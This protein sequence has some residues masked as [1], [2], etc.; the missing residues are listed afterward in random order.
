M[1]NEVIKHVTQTI[2]ERSKASRN[3][4][5]TKI[6][7]LES[8]HMNLDAIEPSNA[9]HV[10]AA[11][12][13]D[14]RVIM[15]SKSTFKLGIISSYNEM[16]SAHAPYVH[17]PELI[18]KIAARLGHSASFIGGVPAICDGVVQGYKGMELSLI[19][20]NIIAMATAIP[21]TCSTADRAILLGTCDKIVPGMLIGAL[22]R[23]YL[24]SYFIPS[25]TMTT[26]ISNSEKSSARQKFHLGDID[27]SQLLETECRCYHGEGTCTFYG[28]ANTNQVMLEALGIQ[29]IDSGL[30]SVCS[31]K[32]AVMEEVIQ[33]ILSAEAPALYEL[34][35]VKSILNA[36]VVWLATGGSTNHTLHLVAI[37][38]SAGIMLRWEDMDALS[39]VVPLLA[40][41]YP[42]GE[43]DVNQFHQAGGVSAVMHELLN[44]GLLHGDV[45]CFN[46]RTIAE[47]IQKKANGIRN[48][49]IIRTTQAP[50]STTGGIRLLQGNIGQGIMKVSAVAPSKRKVTA[51]ARVFESQQAVYNAYHNNE[52]WCDC[53]V[54]L[55]HQG[56]TANG[57]PE[58]HKLMPLLGNVLD[59]GYQVALLTDGRLSGASGKVPAVVH[60][61]PEAQKG[62]PI[63]TIQDGDIIEVDGENGIIHN[64]NAGTTPSATP[65]L[66]D[67]NDHDLFDVIRISLD[68]ANSG[69]M[70]KIVQ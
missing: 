52:L 8:E 55:K 32:S 42:N 64:R 62:G 28:T 24:P 39:A 29:P 38:R 14:R 13:T 37:A 63:A 19:S 17:Y 16:V 57:M 47:H 21:L 53:V 67:E 9:A 61:T 3:T 25:G 35:T 23:G 44:A 40:K 46:N 48:N 60:I 41:I 18:K 11:I 4:Y 59:K 27:S 68:H 58:L 30:A 50:F 69:A 10:L 51:K 22:S 33:A 66:T 12:D 45:K 36:C 15:R 2:E 54:I 56:P 49:A 70:S 31:D 43:A 5:L 6:K 34:I 7:A 1:L 26:G 20:R 65:R